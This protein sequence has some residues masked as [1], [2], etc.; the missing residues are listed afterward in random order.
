MKVLVIGAG[1]TG[2]TTAYYLHKA[3]YEVTV[4]DKEQYAGMKTS[5]A[6]G[7]QLSVSN[8]ETWTSW[9]NVRKGLKWMLKP[10]APFLIRP[11]LSPAKIKWI[12]GFLNETYKG[13]RNKRDNTWETI[14]MGMIARNN[15]QSIVEETGIDFNY[16][17]NGILHFYKDSQYFE[18]AKYSLDSIYRYTDLERHVILPSEVVRLEPKLEGVEGI[19]GG[20]WTESDAMGDIHK[21]CN[22]LADW[23]ADKGVMFQ[24]GVDVDASFADQWHFDYDKVVICA[25]A[26]SARVA[27]LFGDSINVY[28][29]KG[30]SITIRD[31]PENFPTTSLLDDQTKIVTST[32]GDRFRVAGTAELDGWNLDIRK[33][34]IS[35]LLNWVHTNFPEIDTRDYKPWAGL[36]P[37]TPSMLPIVRPGKQKGVYLNTG[38]GHLGWTLSACTA[39]LIVEIM[40]EYD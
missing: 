5:Y 3:G 39:E 27:R 7:G 34:R 19:I 26:D 35:P 20:I 17:K 10:D 32:L 31:N 18:D 28:P 40:Q 30:Y 33:D 14:A 2:V 36:R 25:G 6:N 1:I 23:L 12:A 16:S 11:S 15:Y 37:M 8:S 21:F 38:H 13:D 9:S 29:V 22:G 24:Y 4:F